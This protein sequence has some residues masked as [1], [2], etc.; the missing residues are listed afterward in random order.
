MLYMHKCVQNI[1]FFL[2]NKTKTWNITNLLTIKVNFYLKD[3]EMNDFQKS[4]LKD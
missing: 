3:C 1:F 4:S 2:I